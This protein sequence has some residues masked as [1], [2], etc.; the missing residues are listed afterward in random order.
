VADHPLRPATDRRLGRP[1]PYQLA[2]PTQ[3][4]PLAR[5]P[6]GSPAF[7]L[8][9]YAVLA[10]VSPGYPPLQDRF[11]RVTHPSAALLRPE[12]PFALDLHVL[13]LPPAF[14]LSHDQTLQFNLYPLP[15]SK[16]EHSSNIPGQTPKTRLSAISLS[17]PSQFKQVTCA[18]FLLIANQ[19]VL[20]KRPHLLLDLVFLNNYRIKKYGLPKIWECALYRDECPAQSNK[21]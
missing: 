2:N 16:S 6:Y 7:P 20:H 12:S 4:P 11:L 21:P 18:N 1:L 13:G 19:S 14:N 15:S 17:K 5:G 8:R 9:A 10:R 3:A